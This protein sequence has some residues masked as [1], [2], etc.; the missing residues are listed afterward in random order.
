MNA[1]GRAPM[2][3]REACRRLDLASPATP[4]R[5]HHEP[6][7]HAPLAR[8]ASRA[9]RLLASGELP[10][11]RPDLPLRQPTPAGAAPALAHQAAAPRSLGDHAGPEPDLRAP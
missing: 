5:R 11:R 7:F 9:G 6:G 4:A 3:P 2:T 8:R 1:T 10:V